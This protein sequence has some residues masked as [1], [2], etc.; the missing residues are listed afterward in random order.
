LCIAKARGAENRECQT[1][2]FFSQVIP[3]LSSRFRLAAF[4]AT[5]MLA[6]PGQRINPI[7]DPCPEEGRPRPGHE[8]GT[9]G[10]DRL[11]T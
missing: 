5:H 3:H 11:G 9:R 4:V 2:S 8:G 1:G 10:A 6:Q 7:A